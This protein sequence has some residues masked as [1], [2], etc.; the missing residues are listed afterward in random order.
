MA[1]YVARRPALKIEPPTFNGKG[2][3][4]EW[5]RKLELCYEANVLTGEGKLVW[6]LNLLQDGASRVVNQA[7]P[8]DYDTLMHGTSRDGTLTETTSSTIEMP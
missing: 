8:A 1:Q 6:S 2:D 7:R 3:F 5:K 4:R